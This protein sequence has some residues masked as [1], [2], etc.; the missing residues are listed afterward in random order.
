MPL[1]TQLNE[2]FLRRKKIHKI[3]IL[4]RS[5]A[6]FYGRYNMK[7]IV[8]IFHFKIKPYSI[9]ILTVYILKKLIL[10]E[11]TALI[12]K[13]G[14]A[15]LLHEESHHILLKLTSNRQATNDDKEFFQKFRP[16]KTSTKM[17]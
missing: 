1:V 5:S 10:L 9:A 15:R 13:L 3:L 14:L 12:T 2:L 7:F 6:D 11:T 4:L 17:M 8:N 16:Y